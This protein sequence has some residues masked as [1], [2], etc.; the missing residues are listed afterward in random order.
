M[1]GEPGRIGSEWRR[2]RKVLRFHLHAHKLALA[3]EER[4]KLRGRVWNNVR[5]ERLLPLY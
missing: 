5:I 1:T 3:P 4:K 2:P